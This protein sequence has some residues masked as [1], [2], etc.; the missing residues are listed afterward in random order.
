MVR[1]FLTAIAGYG[2]VG[3]MKTLTQKQRAKILGLESS[4]LCRIEKCK[5]NARGDL[6]RKLAELTKTELALW[7]VGGTG[8]PESRQAA[9]QTWADSAQK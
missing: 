2:I 4:H 8:T 3:F 7:L 1:N 6:A 9:I 5:L